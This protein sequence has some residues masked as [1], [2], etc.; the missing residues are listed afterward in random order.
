MNWS[1]QI[2]L[3]IHRRLIKE[4]IPRAIKCLGMLSETQ[5]WHRP[6]EQSN[7]VGNLVLHCCGNARQWILAT[8]GGGE[9]RRERDDEFDEEGPLPTAELVSLLEALAVDLESLISSLTPEAMTQ[10]YRVQGFDETGIGILIHVAEHFSYHVGQITYVVK[11]M[12][13]KST[14]YYEGLDLN[15][16]GEE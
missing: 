4:S 12:T 11:A 8:M 15:V 2:Q 9:D 16:V 10:I 13:A 3:E 6:N 7:S 1:Q 5:I 14:G